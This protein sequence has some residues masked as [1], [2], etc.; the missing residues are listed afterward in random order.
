MLVPIT[1]IWN[2]SRK[3]KELSEQKI[4]IRKTV[5]FFSYLRLAGR[6]VPHSALLKLAYK[7]GKKS[8]M[9]NKSVGWTQEKAEIAQR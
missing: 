2:V 8:E 5:Y 1:P 4:L 7:S 3:D 9:M 6:S